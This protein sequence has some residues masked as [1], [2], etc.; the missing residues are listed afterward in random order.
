M[1]IGN[2]ISDSYEGSYT[3][4]GPV[5]SDARAWYEEADWAGIIVTPSCQF[6]L[7]SH[8]AHASVNSTTRHINFEEWLVKYDVPLKNKGK[9]ALWAVAWPHDFLDTVKKNQQ[10]LIP[11]VGILAGLLWKEILSKKPAPKGIESK[12]TNTVEFFK[13]YESCIY[14]KVKAGRRNSSD[15]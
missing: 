15:E 10:I 12:Y 4:V 3:I 13:W 6:L 9:R 8:M 14:P 2:Y 7:E 11:P 1:A 5:V